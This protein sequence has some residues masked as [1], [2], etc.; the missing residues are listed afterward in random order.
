MIRGR[1]L[2]D[3]V[4]YEVDGPLYRARNCHC[5]ICRRLSGTAFGTYAQVNSGDF[6]WLSG[7]EH[8]TKYKTSPE[9][10]RCFCNRCG[11]TLG[12]EVQGSMPYITLGS[13]EGDPG[14]RPEA[15]VF[16]GSKASWYELQDEL[17]EFEE[18]PSWNG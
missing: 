6:R 4:R 17:P 15:H 1:C 11:S 14:I 12:V 3:E 8:V 13:V 10:A 18:W 2:C 5:S 16:V 9:V 7:T